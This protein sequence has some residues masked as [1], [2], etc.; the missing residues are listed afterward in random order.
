VNSGDSPELKRWDVLR[1]ILV[2]DIAISRNAFGSPIKMHDT[3]WPVTDPLDETWSRDATELRSWGAVQ[4]NTPS[5]V[6]HQL[7]IGRW[8]AKFGLCPD[9]ECLGHSKCK[10]HV[11]PMHMLPLISSYEALQWGLNGAIIRRWK[12]MKGLLWGTT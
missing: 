10:T 7:R 11:I 8:M 12:P 6:T 5:I 3:D 4:G 9:P 2:E 1:K